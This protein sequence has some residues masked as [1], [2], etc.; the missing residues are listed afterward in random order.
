MWVYS[1]YNLNMYGVQNCIYFQICISWVISIKFGQRINLIITFS[2]SL[3]L[4]TCT[5]ASCRNTQR[6]GSSQ[7]LV[8]QELPLGNQSPE[9]LLCIPWR[10][11]LVLGSFHYHSTIETWRCRLEIRH[12][13]WIFQPSPRKR[14][15]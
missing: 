7:L 15:R 6:E 8:P 12:R 1:T 3:N 9:W 11:F 13:C 4:S 10:F 5:D 14:Y 2:L